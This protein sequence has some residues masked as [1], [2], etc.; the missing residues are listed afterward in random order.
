MYD[1]VD[2]RVLTA[3]EQVVGQWDVTL[4]PNGWKKSKVFSMLFPPLRSMDEDELAMARDKSM[5]CRLSIFSNGTFSMVDGS[6]SNDVLLPLRGTWKLQPNPYC[7]TDRQYDQLVLESYPRVQK[8]ASDESVVQRVI[9]QLKC[10]VWGRY[11]SGPI[12]KFMGYT[13]TKSRMTH[14]TLLWNVQQENLP[15]WI[16]RRVCASFTA[17]PIEGTSDASV[18]VEEEEEDYEC[19]NDD[20]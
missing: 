4:R 10:R 18:Q 13:R 5:Q 11:G 12:R 1:F 14:G 17:K 9:P 6:S 2:A 20:L 3:Y 7:I 19:E 15:P 16:S 8:R